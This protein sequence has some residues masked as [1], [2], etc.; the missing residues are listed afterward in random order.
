MSEMLSDKE[1]AGAISAISEFEPGDRDTLMNLSLRALEELN[2]WREAFAWLGGCGG[3]IHRNGNGW[4]AVTFTLN[5]PMAH[6]ATP[7]EAIES[8]R[9]KVTNE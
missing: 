6:G 5:G 3:A 1:L 8:L 7:L 9:K 2:R 4:L